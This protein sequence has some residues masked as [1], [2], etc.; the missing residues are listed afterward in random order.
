MIFNRKKS[1][2]Q[3][4][5]TYDATNGADYS[6]LTSKEL[7]AAA[8]AQGRLIRGYLIDPMFGGTEEDVNTL[9]LP[10]Q[11]AQLQ[12]RINQQLVD[13]VQAGKEVSLDVRPEYR[14]DSFVPVTLTYNAG[15][16]GV[17]TIK[18]W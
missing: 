2:P 9:P 11:T 14:G 7:V 16:A 4:I 10:P 12:N 8:F 3:G 5:L 15:A 6:D 13:A 1:Q 17:H 18:I